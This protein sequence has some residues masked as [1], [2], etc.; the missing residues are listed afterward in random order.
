[1]ES[2]NKVA[3]KEHRTPDR[4]IQ[5]WVSICLVIFGSALVLAGFI[6]PPVGEISS[7]VL[8]AYGEILTLFGAISGI[9][10]RYKGLINKLTNTNQTK[11]E[12]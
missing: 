10:Y 1:M 9:D 12:E 5:F 2:N 3:Q 11:C 4:T 7:S 8:G 6:V